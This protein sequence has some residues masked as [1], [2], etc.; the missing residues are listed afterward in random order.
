MEHENLVNQRIT[1]LKN[2]IQE[3]INKTISVSDDAYINE[4]NSRKKTYMNELEIAMKELKIV[5]GKTKR[6]NEYKR[7]LRTN[8]SME[9]HRIKNKPN[10]LELMDELQ[11][12]R[13][14]AQIDFQKMSEI[15]SE[16][17]IKEK[18]L[19]PELPGFLFF[20]KDIITAYNICP[21]ILLNENTKNNRIDWLKNQKDNGKL[22]NDLYDKYI[23]YKEH[24]VL[25]NEKDNII[26]YFNKLHED[27]LSPT[28]YE[29]LKD[30]V[31]YLEEYINANIKT[32]KIKDKFK[33][34]VNNISNLVM[35][36]G[37]NIHEYLFVHYKTFIPINV[38]KEQDIT[39][40]STEELI[41]KTSCST[42]RAII[43]VYDDKIIEYKH[44]LESID[45]SQR[46]LRNSISNLNQELYQH[47]YTIL[48]MK[49]E[50]IQR[51]KGKYFK[52]WS[53]LTYDEKLDRYYSFIDYYLAKYLFE[54][55]L[56]DEDSKESVIQNVK[57]LVVHNFD[58]IKFKDIKWNVKNGVIEDIYL[59]K[60][61]EKT[62][63]FYF[64]ESKEKEEKGVRKPSSVKSLL[65]KDTEKM[66][67]EEL[68]L[69]I[70]YLKNNN[71][72]INENMKQ[73][74][75]AFIE[76]LKEK[77]HVKRIT[78]SDKT[79]IFKK[80]DEFHTIIIHNNEK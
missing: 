34:I 76:K 3:I 30:S 74:K 79:E 65:N 73:L 54:P 10:S 49:K 77:L 51:Q 27:Y 44:I 19:C 11:K 45:V 56:I 22:Y 2:S 55:G 75:E 13:Q 9:Y 61:N 12:K 39:L 33:I 52:K 35:E 46:F 67:N 57:E 1:F 63:S 4:L 6:E 70:I 78:T 37:L 14:K 21:Y 72:L 59:L 69:Y 38:K 60:F 64:N 36:T 25:L 15:Q 53:Q 32:K 80:F 23:L 8:D 58:K 47:I 24:N 48:H 50:P 41:L 20:H 40:V 5:K 31:E 42:T 18:E 28:Q 66:I 68:V 16:Y 29:L 17:S 62:A 43:N 71:K 7:I 26:C